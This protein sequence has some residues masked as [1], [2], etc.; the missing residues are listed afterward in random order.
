MYYTY[1]FPLAIVFIVLKR[2]RRQIFL[3]ILL[4][5]LGVTFLNYNEMNSSIGPVFIAIG[6]LFII[7]GLNQK[8]RDEGKD[9]E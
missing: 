6:G 8:R 5:T 4:V 7:I 3:G 1:L 2:Y 9:R